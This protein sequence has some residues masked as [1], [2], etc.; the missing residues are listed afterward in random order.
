MLKR[1]MR[2]DEK[3]P[4]KMAS[5][6]AVGSDTNEYYAIDEILNSRRNSHA[7][8]EY[9]I[10]WKDQPSSEQSWQPVD[11]L[12]AKKQSHQSTSSLEVSRHLLRIERN[13]SL[14]FYRFQFH[15]QSQSECWCD[16]GRFSSRFKVLLMNLTTC[17]FLVYCSSFNFLFVCLLLLFVHIGWSTIESWRSVIQNETYRIKWKRTNANRTSRT[18]IKRTCFTK[19]TGP[20]TSKEFYCHQQKCWADKFKR[21]TKQ[22]ATQRAYRWSSIKVA[23]ALQS[24]RIFGQMGK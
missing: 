1:R 6:A 14:H 19:T 17:I 24:S 18:T 10:K 12:F 3:L 9:L 22:T 8:L 11:N 16:S 23:Q 7:Q 15:T 4:E 2:A 20:K 5:T 21:T 13:I